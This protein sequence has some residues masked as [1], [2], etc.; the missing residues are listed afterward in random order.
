[1]RFR[2]FGLCFLVAAFAWLPLLVL[3][4]A[5]ASQT[6]LPSPTVELCRID[7]SPCQR[8]V[9]L[10]PGEEVTLALIIRAPESANNSDGQS[11]FAWDV[12][13]VLEDSN[14]VDL[15]DMAAR[16]LLFREQDRPQSALAGLNLLNAGT[17]TDPSAGSYYRV[18]NSYSESDSR[19]EYAITT[20]AG[21]AGKL[22]QN[23]LDLE[24]GEEVL[25]G[26]LTLRGNRSGTARI[27]VDSTSPTASKLVLLDPSGELTVVDL[28]VRDSLALVN[29]GPEAER[30]RL[31]GQVWSDV[32]VGQDS[33][34]PFTR[35]FGI[36]FWK[37]GSLP[38]SQGGTD[39]PLPTFSN[40]R[41]DDNG[42]FVI[43]DLSQALV[44]E[45][46]YDL[47]A[48]GE[49]T[50]PYIHENV[51]IEASVHRP[52]DPPQVLTAILGPLRSGDLNGDAVVDIHDLSLFA[53]S[54]GREVRETASG[55]SAD[56]NGDGVVDGQDFSLM[57]A[58][59]G[60]RGD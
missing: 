46:T 20:V 8:E 21:E 24:A 56:F 30:T 32:P 35:P 53:S 17:L 25:L 39:L 26:T 57:A 9:S 28:S 18:K 50:L 58:N 48:I 22:A 15:P 37:Q 10:A 16:G 3:V 60:S 33:F 43:K 13:L 36:E 23:Q 49:G 31:E 5:A 44:P 38:E 59:Y 40:L 6:G 2:R 27:V 54:F 45:G 51:R 1:L 11:L 4:E 14:V 41:A 42:L 19:L 7:V 12:R 55:P 34:Q 52:G 29:V 47:R